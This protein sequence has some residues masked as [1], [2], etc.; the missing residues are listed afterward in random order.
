MQLEGNLIKNNYTKSTPLDFQDA[1]A[2][3]ADLPKLILLNQKRGSESFL[4]RNKKSKEAK[5]GN[6]EMLQ[7]IL[8]RKCTKSYF[9]ILYTNKYLKKQNKPSQPPCHVHERKPKLKSC[10]QKIHTTDFKIH[11][12]LHQH[13]YVKIA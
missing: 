12:S 5:A 6:K 4:K 10:S 2:Q 7:E 3:N 11:L 13:L 9:D 1:N 8:V